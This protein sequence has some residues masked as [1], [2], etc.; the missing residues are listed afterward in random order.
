MTNPLTLNVGVIYYLL[1]FSEYSAGN[2]LASYLWCTLA[3]SFSNIVVVKI[4]PVSSWPPFGSP[5]LMSDVSLHTEISWH[6]ERRGYFFKQILTQPILIGWSDW[7]TQ[8]S[9]AVWFFIFV[10]RQQSLPFS[11]MD[12]WN[13]VQITI[14]SSK[15][16]FNSR[17]QIKSR[18]PTLS[19]LG[20]IFPVRFS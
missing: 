3:L 9:Q 14:Q 19:S 13:W 8:C 1:L 10:H 18:Q 6:R 2:E 5:V 16:R 7:S 20:H 11:Q 12:W 17:M 15:S 4:L